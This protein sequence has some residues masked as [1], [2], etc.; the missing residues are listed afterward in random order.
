MASVLSNGAAPVPEPT[1]A[2]VFAIGFATI[3]ASC[4]SKAYRL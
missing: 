4:R 1:A 3:A 2:L